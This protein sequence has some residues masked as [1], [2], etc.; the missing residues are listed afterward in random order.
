MAAMGKVRTGP[1]FDEVKGELARLCARF[2]VQ[3]LELFGSAATGAFDP[4]RSDIDFLVELG[5]ATGMTPFQQYFGLKESLESLFGRSVDLVMVG[6]PQNR[7]FLA[8]MNRS[9]RLLYAA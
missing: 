4:E 1:D 5:E 2:A 9:R 3:R 8:S 6:A 7:H